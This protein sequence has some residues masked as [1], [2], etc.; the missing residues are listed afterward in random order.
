MVG[1]AGNRD[2]CKEPHTVVPW[3]EDG[4]SSMGLGEM[5]EWHLQE[6]EQCD[7]YSTEGGMKGKEEPRTAPGAL[8]PAPS[9]SSCILS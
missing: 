4:G 3:R 8:G 1:T 7:L 2:R 5:D 6:E 9:D